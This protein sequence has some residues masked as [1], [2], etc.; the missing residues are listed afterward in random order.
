VE[1]AVMTTM[2]IS[3]IAFVIGVATGAIWTA[4]RAQRKFNA[5]C[6]D[7]MKSMPPWQ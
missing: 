2:C 1:E 3:L 4:N 7:L 6:E 5:F